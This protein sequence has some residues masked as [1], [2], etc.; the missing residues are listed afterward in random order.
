MKKCC[1]PDTCCGKAH[2][3]DAEPKPEPQFK[4]GNMVFSLING[5][6]EVTHQYPDGSIQVGGW[7]YTSKGAW[8][9]KGMQIL[10]HD[11][12]TII[13]AKRKVK[14]WRWAHLHSGMAKGS[15]ISSHYSEKDVVHQCSSLDKN[16]IIGE[17]IV[18]LPWTE[19]EVEE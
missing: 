17:T 3:C 10:F 18:K 15:V 6:V 5:W 7:V 8:T 9:E 11:K 14:K 13:P 1:S 12:P 16:V 19:I 4:V 2:D